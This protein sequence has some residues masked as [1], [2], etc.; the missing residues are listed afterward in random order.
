MSS[1]VSS[2][3]GIFSS[4]ITGLQGIVSLLSSEFGGSGGPIPDAPG[5]GYRHHSFQMQGVVL[6]ERHL[7]WQREGGSVP[8]CPGEHVGWHGTPV[9]VSPALQQNVTVPALSIRHERQD[10]QGRSP[11]VISALA[12]AF[13]I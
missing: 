8:R 4:G 10:V 13:S 12:P 1:N 3:E 11:P 7:R 5:G 9:F 2:L 6:L